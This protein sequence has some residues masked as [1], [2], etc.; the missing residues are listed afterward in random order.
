MPKTGLR[1]I[2]SPAGESA[3]NGQQQVSREKEQ[4][5]KKQNAQ[6]CAGWMIRQN[7][8]DEEQQKQ[9]EDER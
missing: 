6:D 9:Q 8:W 4:D 2:R 5:N 7:N 1:R 3:E